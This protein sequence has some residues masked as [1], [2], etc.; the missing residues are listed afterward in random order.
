LRFIVATLSLPH[1]A[2]L[3]IMDELTSGLDSFAKILD[4]TMRKSWEEAIKQG[5][6][7]VDNTGKLKKIDISEIE[8][9]DIRKR[10]EELRVKQLEVFSSKTIKKQMTESSKD[11]LL[12]AKNKKIKELAEE[13]KNLKQQLMYLQ[14]KIY[15]KG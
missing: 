10:I 7:R 15:D 9:E 3:L 1:Q 12:L 5:L 2:D 6:F 11:A 4:T 13:V 14:G 8:N